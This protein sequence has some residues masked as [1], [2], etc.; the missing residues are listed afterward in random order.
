[1]ASVTAPGQNGAED[2][3]GRVGPML[4]PQ[5]RRIGLETAEMA[6]GFFA[7]TR[8]FRNSRFARNRVCAT[9]KFRAKAACGP[10]HHSQKRLQARPFRAKRP[11]STAAETA[12]APSRSLWRTS[13]AR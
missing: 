12:S 10:R 5:I 6:G 4:R 13:P 3:S 11:R 7:R 9:E 8:G 2:S 1:M